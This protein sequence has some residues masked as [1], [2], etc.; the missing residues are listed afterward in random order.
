MGKQ[1]GQGGGLVILNEEIISSIPP[2]ILQHHPVVII[3]MY[4][5]KINGIP[6]LSTVFRVVKL[7]TCTELLNTKIET[8]VA[9]LLVIVDTYM[10]RGFGILV[11][12]ADYA[13]EAVRT[14]EDFMATSITF[15]T[16]SED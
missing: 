5:V 13:F 14:N 11:I 15:N 9:V 6:F 3:G 12:A 16:M 4:V 1:R 2:H 7:G 8:I 10:S